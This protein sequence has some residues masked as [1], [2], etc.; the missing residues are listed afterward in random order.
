MEAGKTFVIGDIHGAFKALLQC[1]ERSAFDY[2]RDTLICLGDVCD[3]W[4][5]TKECVNELLKI[6]KLIYLMGN[7]DYWAVQWM[8][9][10]DIPDAWLLN[11]GQATIDSY[12]NNHS[13]HLQFLE[14]A[15]DYYMIRNQL[16]V[17]AGILHSTPFED[18][19]R[20]IFLW[21]RTLFSEAWALKEAGKEKQL[22]EFEEIYIGHTPVHRFGYLHP[23]KAC[24]VWMMDTGAG[25]DG[26]LNIMDIASKEY[27]CSD[28]VPDLYPDYPG[29]N[30][31]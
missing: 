4:P 24:E 6:N 16:F 17:H 29:R 15:L 18:Q 12:Q 3:G 30:M 2:H 8:S 10:G 26:V 27:F 7:H 31:R 1:L 20:E 23:I 14:K 21:D 11:G 5:E 25:W 22:T 13:T 19:R 28:L 9:T